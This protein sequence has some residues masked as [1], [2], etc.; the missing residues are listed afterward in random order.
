M[1][2]H[3]SFRIHRNSIL[4]CARENLVVNAALVAAANL[5]ANV[6]PSANACV[7]MGFGNGS[8]APAVTDTGLSGSSKY[9]NALTG[10]SFP[11]AGSVQF[12]F[13]L[14]GSDTGAEGI[15]ITEIGLFGNSASV[16]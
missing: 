7:A 12:A 16:T 14:T 3:G 8:T 11:S 1:A 6:S 10:H 2:L 15:T 5:T 4:F 9:F 13:A